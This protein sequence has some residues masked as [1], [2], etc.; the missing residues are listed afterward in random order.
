MHAYHH[1]PGSNA[2]GLPLGYP[3]PSQEYSQ[4][5]T[6]PERSNLGSQHLHDDPFWMQGI[7]EL[8]SQQATAGR[9]SG[10]PGIALSHQ[11]SQELPAQLTDPSLEPSPS[12]LQPATSEE[13]PLTDPA[14][15]PSFLGG[16]QD[17]HMS[18]GMDDIFTQ[19]P[20]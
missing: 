9:Q 8:G 13:L 2:A 10:P 6:A 12:L 17:H 11:L 3:N 15:A 20:H 19:W 5:F 16:D 7:S 18:E 14:L 4:Q 1:W